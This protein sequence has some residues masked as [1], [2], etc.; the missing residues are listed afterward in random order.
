MSISIDT[1]TLI[2]AFICALIVVGCEFYSF[3]KRV[4]YQDAHTDL[5]IITVNLIAKIDND[6]ESNDFYKGAFWVL[7]NIMHKEK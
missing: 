7:D 1:I 6:E 3:G 2:S 4:G 5:T